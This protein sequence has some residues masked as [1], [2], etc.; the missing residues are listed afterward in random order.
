MRLLA[1]V[2]A[3]MVG[4]WLGQVA[5]LP[6]GAVDMATWPKDA[7]QLARQVVVRA[8]HG[9]KPFAVVDKRWSRI[10]VFDGDG[11]LV[12]RSA[13]LLGSAL[14][15]ESAN[16]VGRR[17]QQG[18]LRN[19]DR[20]TPA[21]LFHAETGRN[22]QGEAIV[23]I[24]YAAALAIHRL[25]D[26]PDHDRRSQR[27]AGDDPGLRRVSAGCV[28]VPG[29][30]YDTVVQPLLGQRRGLVYVMPEATPQNGTVA[31]AL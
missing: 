26:G 15:D 16:G 3:G 28:V 4:L 18:R 29:A 23:W 14:G 5:A 24:D 7:L 30:F 21:G 11:Q 19:S 31:S 6:A 12:G 8:D 9:R 25:R 27:L 13:V 2:L 10:L 17:A 1:R 22:R 20:T